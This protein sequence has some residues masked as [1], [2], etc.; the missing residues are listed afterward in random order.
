MRNGRKQVLAAPQSVGRSTKP[1]SAR[2]KA[3]VKAMTHPPV[4]QLYSINSNPDNWSDAWFHH[5][6]L[7]GY[8]FGQMEWL[9]YL[10]GD[11]VGCSVTQR[12]KMISLTFAERCDFAQSN[13][14]PRIRDQALRLEWSEILNEVRKCGKMRNDILHNPLELNLSEIL[15]HGVKVDQGIRLLKKGGR[16]LKIG[17]VQHYTRTMV[18]LHQR[19]L[20]LLARTPPPVA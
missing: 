12:R 16:I 9:P 11:R 1:S 15:H 14:V 20:D 4:R 18:D 2:G 13:F 17:D 7:V 3:L 5:I 10:F 8:Y 19:I 6:G